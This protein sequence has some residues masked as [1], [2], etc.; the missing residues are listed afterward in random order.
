[1]GTAAFFASLKKVESVATR[2]EEVTS[3]LTLGMLST[4]ER[5]YWIQ[6]TS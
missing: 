6:S 4:R 2:L 5:Q 1:M 3:L